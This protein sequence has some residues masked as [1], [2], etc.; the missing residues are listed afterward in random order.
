MD[1]IWGGFMDKI[2]EE[3]KQEV[4]EVSETPE[5][6]AKRALN[7]K[8]KKRRRRHRQTEAKSQLARKQS[9]FKLLICYPK[10]TSHSGYIYFFKHRCIY[11][12]IKHLIYKIHSK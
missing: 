1:R 2:P 4:S 8:T 6:K 5:T 12:T 9:K 11:S 3:K 7:E 10:C